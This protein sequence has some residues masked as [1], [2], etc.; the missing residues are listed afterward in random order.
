MCGVFVYF[1]G[2]ITGL[3]TVKLNVAAGLIMIFIGIFFGLLAI[4][5]FASLVKVH[6]WRQLD[7]DCFTVVLK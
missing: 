4:I 7:V 6:Q 5:S 3:T 2:I 1:S